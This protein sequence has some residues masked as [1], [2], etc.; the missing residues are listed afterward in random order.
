MQRGLGDVHQ[1]RHLRLVLLDLP[2]QLAAD[3]AGGSADKHHP[4]VQDLAHVL[5][6]DADL[7]TL[8][9][10]LD[11]NGVDAADTLH[12]DFVQIL[13]LGEIRR[14][15]DM[16]I[17]VNEDLQ[18]RRRVDLFHLHRRNNDMLH[19][20]LC[21]PGE[22]FLIQLPDTQTGEVV[23]MSLGAVGDEA[24]RS[25]GGVTHGAEHLGY[26]Q[27]CRLSTVD[28][29]KRT[30]LVALE[31]LSQ[32]LDT[33]TQREE[34]HKGRGHID[35]EHGIEERMPAGVVIQDDIERTQQQADTHIRQQHFDRIYKSRIAQDARIGME[36]P[37][38]Q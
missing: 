38:G 35:S 22:Q 16:D 23:A 21:H 27:T 15:E 2:H 4:T 20:V 7:R 19:M 17:M 33:H 13:I 11:A 5:G 29:D 26:R 36:G 3:T 32:R 28:H 24:D 25:I 14:G 31:V 8:Q 9:Q 10:V 1:D 37:E 6:I 18:I 12:V 30:T 34:Q